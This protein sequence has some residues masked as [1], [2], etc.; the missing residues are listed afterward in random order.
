M[1]LDLKNELNSLGPFNKNV[2]GGLIFATIIIF[3]YCYFGSFSFF[4]K[5]FSN[6]ANSEYWS[7]IYH[8]VSAFVLFFVVGII[9]M[10]FVLKQNL[11]DFGMKKGEWKLGLILVGIATI[12]IPLLTLTTPLDSDMAST[13]PMIDFQSQSAG[14]LV[15][16]FVSYILYYIGWEFLFRGILLLNL[17][18]GGLNPLT[19]I[20]ISTIVSAL[21]HTCIADFGKPMVETLSAIGAGV[22]FG[23]ITWR[24]KS[25]YYS[26]YMHILTGI[27]TDMFIFLLV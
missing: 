14:F 21:I 11:A 2:H 19:V 16:Y 7:V 25:L 10:K 1:K 20:L 3:I 27:C 26:L 17:E 24:T 9:F 5:H 18:K 6:V 12:I 15:L 4:N 13:Y 23:F 22:I 8:N